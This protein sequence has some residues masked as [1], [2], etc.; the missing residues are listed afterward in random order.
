MVWPMDIALYNAHSIEQLSWPDTAEGRYAQRF[1][2]PLIKNGIAS[3]ID[4]IQADLFA[5][6]VDAFVFP[7]LVP[8]ACDSNSYVCSPYRHYIT[9]GEDYAYLIPHAP[10][11]YLF[12][13]LLA[14]FGVFGK[15]LDKVLYVNHWL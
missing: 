1:L 2:E 9:Y 11:R 12:K 6:K 7:L 13:K 5:L 14:L 3:Y 10:L 8:Q 15:R 4:N